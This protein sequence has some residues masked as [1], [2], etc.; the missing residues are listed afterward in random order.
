MFNFAQIIAALFFGTYERAYEFRAAK[1]KNE[2]VG[3]G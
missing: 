3:C 2:D 1:R